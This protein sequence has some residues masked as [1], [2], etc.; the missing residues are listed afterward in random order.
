[1]VVNKYFNVA[2]IFVILI[3]FFWFSDLL[4]L[5]FFSDD[6]LVIY[7]LQTEGLNNKTFFRP[8][9]D[10]S[11]LLDWKIFGNRPFVFH[12]MNIIIHL[13][14]AFMIYVVSKK[15]IQYIR[16][17]YPSISLVALLTSSLFIFL[18][19]H[20]ETYIWIV[21]R[22][23][24]LSCLLSLL[25]LYFFIIY[26]IKRRKP[27]YWL[28]LAFYFVALLGYETAVIVPLI[29]VG[30]Q[31]F[32]NKIDKFFFSELVG[33]IIIFSCY[34]L[35]SLI[36]TEGIHNNEYL[37]LDIQLIL[38]AKNFIA[39]VG[40]SFIPPQ[41]NAT[42]FIIKV[43]SLVFLLVGLM[44]N[45]FKND[46]QSTKL[47]ILQLG[48]FF[49]SILPAITVGIDTHDYEGG[50]FIYQSSFFSCFLLATILAQLFRNNRTIFLL[51]IVAMVAYF[52][53]ENL[54]VKKNW[55]RAGDIVNKTLDELIV[56]KNVNYF[57]D[58]PDAINGAYVFRNG[59]KEA[60]LING[61]SD[62]EAKFITIQ[63]ADT[64]N[65]Q[66]NS[67]IF[68]FNKIDNDIKTIIK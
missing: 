35:L 24:M 4:G 16:P 17:L 46:S 26:K 25:S 56:S 11:L 3:A 36:T 33:Y 8:L 54:Q 15:M 64:I 14:N 29:L 65:A 10:A 18:P 34:Y 1:M 12:L 48:L 6:F 68:I 9:G 67:K 41:A 21:G 62:S 23:I 50:R 58:F 13:I 40:R 42:T 43:G 7:R 31:V 20:A 37:R 28:S 38:I 60:F 27:L 49:I 30:I 5:P 59:L 52:L 61:K 53:F 2:I 45:F 22:G 51:L 63:L 39:L 47:L 44:L 55:E 32:K 57:V 19:Y 66:P